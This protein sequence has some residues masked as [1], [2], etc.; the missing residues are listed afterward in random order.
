MESGIRV[1]FCDFN[2]PN[3]ACFIGRKALTLRNN[4]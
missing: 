4:K 1:E 3:P 2:Q